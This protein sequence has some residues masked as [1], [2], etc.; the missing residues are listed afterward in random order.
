MVT[1]ARSEHWGSVWATRAPDEVSWFQAE[2]TTSVR[3][4]VGAA[5]AAMAPSGGDASSARIVDIG[6]GASVLVDRLL[7][8]GCRDLT[9]VDI[10]AA[11]LDIVRDRVGD[12]AGLVE[13]VVADVT[14]WEPSKSFD[15][16]HDRA[17]FHFLVDD[18]LRA[19][20]VD[21]VGRAVRPGGA[22]VLGTFA[23]DGPEQCSGLPV[24]RWSAE[25][26]AAEFGALFEL[27]HH[28]REVHRTPG[29]G[30]QPFTWVVLRRLTSPSRTP[31]STSAGP[32]RPPR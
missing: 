7:D 3:L 12:R 30:E 5:E 9:V 8:R 21:T 25:A 20:Y 32:A 23:V 1:D 29:G 15:V 31:R 26:L 28:E 24:R 16:W 18:S 13:F 11:A 2:P 6:A 27:V 22:V 19:R 10:S 17:V 14:S 4:V